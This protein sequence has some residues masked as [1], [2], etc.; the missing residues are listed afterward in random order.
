MIPGFERNLTITVSILKAVASDKIY[1]CFKS[2]RLLSH[3]SSKFPY[4][5]VFL[6]VC[7]S[8]WQGGRKI[9]VMFYRS[10]VVV[11]PN[12]A[13]YFILYQCSTQ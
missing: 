13:I 4:T 9:R 5:A 3:N 6:F 8:D 2:I 7:L 12:K 11:V 1:A 10:Y